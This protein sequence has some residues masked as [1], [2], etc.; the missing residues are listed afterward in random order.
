MNDF[1]TKELA[2]HVGSDEVLSLLTGI[3][4]QSTSRAKRNGITHRE[5]L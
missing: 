2:K 3:R 4:K 5:G 1:N